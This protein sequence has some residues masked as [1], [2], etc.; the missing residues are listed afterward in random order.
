MKSTAFLFPELVI[1]DNKP[2]EAQSLPI[3]ECKQHV[4]LKPED[5]TDPTVIAKCKRCGLL[6]VRRDSRPMPDILAA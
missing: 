6:M 3:D 2:I 1:K 5:S 4:W